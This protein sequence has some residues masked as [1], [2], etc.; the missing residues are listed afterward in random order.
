[1]NV[2]PYLTRVFVLRFIVGRTIKDGVVRRE[3]GL[4]GDEVVFFEVVNER[5]YVFLG[6]TVQFADFFEI[7]ATAEILIFVFDFE[8]VAIGLSAIL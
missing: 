4:F 3:N 6:I 1:M 2:V 8:V 5:V 7:V